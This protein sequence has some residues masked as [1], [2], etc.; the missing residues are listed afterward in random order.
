MLN[1]TVTETFQIEVNSELELELQRNMDDNFPVQRVH[2]HLRRQQGL[3]LVIQL[4]SG[5][6]LAKIQI[7]HG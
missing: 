1:L 5:R 7:H 6:H 2:F 3:L 4:L